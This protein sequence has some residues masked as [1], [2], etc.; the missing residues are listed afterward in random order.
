MNE[1]SMYRGNNR[2]VEITIDQKSTGLA[3][4]L[5][6]CIITMFIKKNINDSDE[7]AIITKSTEMLAEGKITSE[8]NGLVE[9]YLIPVDTNDV[10]SDLK[11]N[12]PYPVDFKVTTPEN[13][14]KIYTV[15]RTWFTILTR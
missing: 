4:N 6:D 13:P 12:V 15:L 11:D 1:I 3:Y 9:F 7:N 8:L 10:V 5:T 2:R 14:V